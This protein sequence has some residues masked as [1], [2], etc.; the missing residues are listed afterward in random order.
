MVGAKAAARVSGLV[1]G[2]VC[3]GAE[4][5]VPEPSVGTQGQLCRE[6]ITPKLQPY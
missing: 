1:F 3:E 6:E 4:L 2:A 5:P